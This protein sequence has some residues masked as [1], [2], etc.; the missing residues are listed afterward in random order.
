[1]KRILVALAICGTTI[2]VTVGHVFAQATPAAPVIVVPPDPLANPADS[3]G[4]VEKL[5]RSGAIT[6]SVIVA[7]FMVLLVLQQ[8][9]PWF[10]KGWRIVWVPALLGGLTMLIDGISRGMTPNASMVI[11][12]LTTTLASA[13]QRKPAAPSSPPPSPAT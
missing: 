10:S 12:A 4:A 7:G 13:L 3:M 9:V 5:W 6:S 8:R 11:V 1:M 2:G